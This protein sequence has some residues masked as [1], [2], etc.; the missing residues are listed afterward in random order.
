MAEAAVLRDEEAAFL[1]D[2]RGH[3]GARAASALVEIGTRMGLD[4]CG[5]D[6]AVLP[7]GTLLLFECNAAMLVRHTAQPAMFDYKR[8]PAERIR[9]ALS[10][11]L[12][13]RAAAA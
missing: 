11:L 4:Y 3:V 2:W 10:R 13:R 1:A 8:A 6:C 5:I 9:D 12:E 7:D